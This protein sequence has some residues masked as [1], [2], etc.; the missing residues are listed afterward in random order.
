MIIGNALQFSTFMKAL[1]F[2]NSLSGHRPHY[3]AVL[4]R[5]LLDFGVEL[6]CALPEVLHSDPASQEFLSDIVEHSQ[7]FGLPAIADNLTVA[8]NGNARLSMLR[9]CVEKFKDH[10]IFVPYAD[11]ISQAWGMKMFP[12]KAIPKCQGIEGLM[13]RGRFAYPN[14]GWKN[15]L[16]AEVSWQL[17]KR[18]RWDVLHQLDQVVF[19]EI[20]RRGTRIE[21]RLIP[22][23]VEAPVAADKDA[24]RAA[25]G[26][27][28]DKFVIACPGAV[29]ERKGSDRLLD[30]VASLD[31]REIQLVLF[32]KHS[33]VLE[34]K[35][36]KTNSVSVRSVNRFA[37][38]Q[39]FEQLFAASDLIAVCY[40]R[41][42]GSASILLRA[43]AA[44]KSIVASDWGW[45]GWVA[46]KFKLGEVCDPQSIASIA[47]AIQN[48]RSKIGQELP[49]PAR[50]FI[51]YHTPENHVAHWT[52]RFCDIN[53]VEPL[54]RIDID[55][56]YSVSESGT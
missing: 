56:V 48:A 44:G 24:A 7:H 6:V 11:G 26:I 4:A 18:A 29:N 2:E 15:R 17:Q 41:H 3:V 39:E 36:R 40:P 9:G 51:K 10:Y 53:G 22:D 14:H 45:I 5:Q 52:R 25:L 20:V 47:Q 16:S 21:N 46:K 50:Q 30:A 43:V 49:E 27:E 35:V 23:V 37:T 13:M 34:E 1:V 54:D 12:G 31:E 28:T 33:A 55:Q 19:E 32:G 8:K 42:I 38:Q